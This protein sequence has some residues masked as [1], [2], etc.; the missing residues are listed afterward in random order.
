MT[1]NRLYEGGGRL[2]SSEKITYVGEQLKIWSLVYGATQTAVNAD[3]THPL[4]TKKTL[5]TFEQTLAR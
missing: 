3:H 2:I 5:K 4:M 1:E